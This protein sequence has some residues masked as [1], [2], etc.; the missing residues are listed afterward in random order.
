M[1][2]YYK[3]NLKKPI[4]IFF[5]IDMALLMTKSTVLSKLIN[6]LTINI[7]IKQKQN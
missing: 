4:T 2:I 6:K 7:L 1:I 5:S 3:D